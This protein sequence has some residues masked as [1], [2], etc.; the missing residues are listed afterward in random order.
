MPRAL[1][2]DDSEDIRLLVGHVLQR[3]GFEVSEA[4]SGREALQHLTAAGL[5]DVIV[6]DVQMPMMDGW[7][8]LAAIRLTPDMADLPVVLCTVRSGPADRARAWSLGCDGYV[9]KP[10]A[11]EQLL[12]EI[13]AAAAR[14]GPERRAEREQYRQERLAD[15]RNELLAEG[16]ADAWKFAR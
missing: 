10:F 12:S 3:G 2:V 8:T 6:L 4:A 16:R 5:P 15:A 14:R 1:I 9:V 13:V 11:V 7:A